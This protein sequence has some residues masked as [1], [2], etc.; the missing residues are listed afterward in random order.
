MRRRLFICLLVGAFGLSGVYGPSGAALAQT[1]VPKFY[2]DL[3]PE[4]LDPNA[5]P[6][7]VAI[8]HSGNG[9][10]ILRFAFKSENG[11]AGPLEL[12]P[13][14]QDCNRNGSTVDDRT[15]YQNI[16]GDTNGNGVYD[17][18]NTSVPPGP[19]GIVR[20]RK[21]GCF[22]FDARPGHM[23]WH[24]ENYAKYSLLD[25][26]GTKVGGRS[27]VGFCLTDED[28]VDSSLPGYPSHRVYRSCAD[29]TIQGISVGWDDVYGPFLAGQSIVIQGLPNG[30]YCLVS[31]A[32]PKNVIRE[33][34]D[35]NNQVR[36]PLDITGDTVQITGTTC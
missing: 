26:N 7:D 18:P 20:T 25:S 28:P 14:R 29:L 6:V 1:T 34:L 16:Y 19:D 22:T 12:Q 8:D 5:S 21:V 2:P 11:G 36:T 15:A 23:H 3:I 31:K 32:D 27:K 33:T 30:S 10:K 24:F 13:K 17:P 4:Q 35:T 9:N